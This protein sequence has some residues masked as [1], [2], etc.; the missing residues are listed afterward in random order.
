MESSQVTEINLVHGPKHES[1]DGSLLPAPQK[2]QLTPYFI[3]KRL[4]KGVATCTQHYC[5]DTQQTVKWRNCPSAIL[6]PEEDS[7]ENFP[8]NFFSELFRKNLLPEEEFVSSGSIHKQLPEERH[9][10]CF[11]KKLL[12]EDFHFLP[13]EASSGS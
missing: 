4:R 9:P 5:W 6:L 7:S 12:P 3:T 11:R 2:S 10:E 8:E 1:I 13:E